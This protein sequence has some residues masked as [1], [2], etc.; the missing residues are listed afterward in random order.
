MIAINPTAKLRIHETP[1]PR[2]TSLAFSEGSSDP[3]LRIIL[4]RKIAAQW[5]GWLWNRRVEYRAICSSVRLF[6]RT[7]HSFTCS[8]LLA[9]LVRSAA[10]RRLVPLLAHSLPPE[11]VGQWN[12][13]VQFSRCSESLCDVCIFSR[14]SCSASWAM[15]LA[16]SRVLS[17]D[18]GAVMRQWHIPIIVTHFLCVLGTGNEMIHW[19]AWKSEHFSFCFSSCFLLFL[20][21]L[22]TIKEKK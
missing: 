10:L 11:L 22:I 15:E 13:F 4:D 12:I 6:A 18:M 19:G 7:A 21:F 3:R 2:L 9:S 17:V 20:W 8:A 16:S 14:S 1:I 5:V